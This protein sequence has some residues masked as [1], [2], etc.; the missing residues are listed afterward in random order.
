[1][2]FK[3]VHERKSPMPT[4]PSSLNRDSP[5]SP[6]PATMLAPEMSMSASRPSVGLPSE[7]RPAMLRNMRRS[8]PLSG[9]ASDM[10]VYLSAS[11]PMSVARMPASPS[12]IADEVVC[13]SASPTVSPLRFAAK[14]FIVYVTF[15]CNPSIHR[16]NIPFASASSL[17]TYVFS[18]LPL[19]SLRTMRQPLIV[20]LSPP[21]SAML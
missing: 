19:W 15:G 13:C 3:A 18:S 6:P 17:C 21:S 9:P 20:I 1:M 16:R 12:T 7:S 11:L 2:L 10:L 8:S 14:G 4:T 5:Y